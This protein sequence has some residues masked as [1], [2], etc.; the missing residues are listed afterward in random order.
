MV[1]ATG[2]EAA[3]SPS[4]AARLADPPSGT[5]CY[6][7]AHEAARVSAA[8]HELEEVPEG[9]SS[10]PKLVGNYL[11]TFAIFGGLAALFYYPGR[12][13]PGAILIALIGA[14][15]GSTVRGLN[16]AGLAFAAGGFTIGMIIAVALERPIF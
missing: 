4:R 10:W 5:R 15:F 1:A 16:A 9:R 2:A 8:E 3:A 11:S 6:T 7:R 12:I 14:G 13:G